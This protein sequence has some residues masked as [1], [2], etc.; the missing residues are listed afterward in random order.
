MPFD[1]E[2]NDVYT[3]FILQT[4]IDEGFEV[5]RADS[6]NNQRNI[7]HDIV[8]SISEADIVIADLTS[9]N[10]NVY[11]ELGI[12]HALGKPVILLTQDIDEVPFDLRPYRL[13]LYS[14]HFAQIEKARHEL[15]DSARGFING[16]SKFGN[17]VSDYKAVH[18][19]DV[20]TSDQPRTREHREEPSGDELQ[21]GEGEEWG[22]LDHLDSLEEGY[23]KLTELLTESN[24]HITDLGNV[25]VETGDKLTSIN[26]DGSPGARFHIRKVLQ[27][28]AERV[29]DLASNLKRKNQT[30]EE[31]SKRI[32]I[33]LEFVIAYHGNS[34]SNAEALKKSLSDLA[35]TRDVARNAQTSMNHLFD[36][37]EKVPKIEAQTNRSLKLAKNE[38]Q[39][40]ANNIE[41]T[42]ATISR[43]ILLGEETLANFES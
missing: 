42:V 19:R 20:N 16:T 40:L 12:A 39:Y 7:L 27:G 9:S 43:A 34:I 4:L 14:V 41:K 3:L 35:Q 5:A 33:D 6:I 26:R 24:E 25:S 21:E 10:P 32:A 2:L 15:R 8:G 28:Y 37:I 31:I 11:Y 23:A 22:F 13:L 17:P 1:Q 36:T 29:G 18:H 30:Y 38:V